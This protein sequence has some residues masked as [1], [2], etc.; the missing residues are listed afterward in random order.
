M[1]TDS[2]S[3]EFRFKRVEIVSVRAGRECWLRAKFCFPK[4]GDNG[5]CLPADGN[6]Q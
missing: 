1:W 3:Q 6:D 5:A 2:S 4:M